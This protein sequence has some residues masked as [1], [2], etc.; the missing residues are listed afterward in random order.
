M[1][2]RPSTPSTPCNHAWVAVTHPADEWVPVPH[3]SEVCIHCD[4]RS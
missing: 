3:T 2:A 1:A 4:A